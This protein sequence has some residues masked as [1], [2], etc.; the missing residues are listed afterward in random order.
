MSRKNDGIN[1]TILGW[2][3]RVHPE[4][5]WAIKEMPPTVTFKDMENSMATG[6]GMGEAEH[7]SDTAT[8]ELMLDR[9]AELLDKDVDELIDWCNANFRERVRREYKAKHPKAKK[10]DIKK[11]R[12]LAVA[13]EVAVRDL[14]SAL[15]SVDCLA[16]GDGLG[17]DG[18]AEFRSTF[19][20]A[21]SL[22]SDADGVLSEADYLL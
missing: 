11:L 18:I 5:L 6:Q 3:K 19:Y 8:R 10:P 9:L 12:D 13:A 7:H 14:A 15:S 22:L 17:K 4:E 20:K 1:E 21:T 16:L 2:F